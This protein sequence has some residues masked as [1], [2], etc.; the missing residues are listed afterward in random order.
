MIVTTTELVSRASAAADMRDNFVTPTQW[1]YWA[2]QER[3][4][5]DLFLARSGWP[6]PI[7]TSTITV[8]GSENGSYSLAPTDQPG[9]M[10][11]VAVHQVKDQRTRLLKH[12]NVVDFLSRT[13][14]YTGSPRG[15]ALFYRISWSGHDLTLNFYPEPAAGETYLVTYIAQ[16]TKLSLSDEGVYA[17]TN[18]TQSS[19]TKAVL[20][21]RAS[22]TDGNGITVTY[23]LGFTPMNITEGVS[24]VE[25]DIETGVSTWEDF[26]DLINGS[27]T[28]LSVATETGT[29]LISGTA[30]TS[31]ATAGGESALS[32]G[33]ATSVSYPMG[34]EERIVLGMA[35]RALIK[36]ES[37]T[38]AI[39]SEIALWESRIEEACWGRVLA[40]TPSVRN[41]DQLIYGWRDR[42][43]IPP[44]GYW[45]F[46]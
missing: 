6:L 33:Y 19:T 23:N 16:P 11:I 20:Q 26:Y 9:V 10:A 22:G 15:N 46:V 7:S 42:H 31:S 39:D 28:L 45:I 43:E 30:I 13:P 1:M 34:W 38:R 27:S 3:L 5:L 14:G 18:V 29:G 40:D 17:T 21:A 8:T 44:Y 24:S 36:E 4:S 25:I 41:S 2:T 35:R 12:Q 37:D 32:L